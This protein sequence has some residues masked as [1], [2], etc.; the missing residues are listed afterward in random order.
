M[1]P[2]A[3]LLEVVLQNCRGRVDG[4]VV[5]YLQLALAKLQTA[6]NRTLKVGA[7]VGWGVYQHG[8]CV[9]ASRG[10]RAGRTI[11]SLPAIH[12]AQPLLAQ[13]PAACHR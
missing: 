3:K 13:A 8:V 6:T 11:R 2:A 12:P 4:Y 9:S 5:P 10:V 7:W 1:V